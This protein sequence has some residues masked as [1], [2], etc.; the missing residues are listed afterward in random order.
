M[1]AVQKRFRDQRHAAVDVAEGP[2]ERLWRLFDSFDAYSIVFAGQLHHR[3]SKAKRMPRA[4]AN[5]LS[6]TQRMKMS[7]FRGDT[8]KTLSSM[9]RGWRPWLERSTIGAPKCRGKVFWT[10]FTTPRVSLSPIETYFV[11]KPTPTEADVVPKANS[12]RDRF[13]PEPVPIESD[14]VISHFFSKHICIE[15]K[16]LSIPIWSPKPFPL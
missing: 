13:F 6:A 12:Y 10:A 14:C 11:A 16:F 1:C 2:R 7:S 8:R 9:S 3:G 5:P 15:G 4:N